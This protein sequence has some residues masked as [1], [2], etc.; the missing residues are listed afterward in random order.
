MNK[1]TL[2]EI[3]E[4]LLDELK[5]EAW[6]CEQMEHTPRRVAEFYAEFL[7]PSDFKF[8]VFKN[9]GNRGMLAEKNIPFYSLCSHHM[10]P[11]YG[12]VDVGYIPDKHYVGISKLARVV[13]HFARDLNMQET[14]TENIANF[15]D[16]K[17]KPLGV[18]VVS[19]A[20]HTCQEM[21]GI[22][23]QSETIYSCI[24]GAFED[25]KARQEFLEL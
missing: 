10:L 9:S 16:E 2:T 6:H 18:M 15:L 1:E 3:T 8:T 25:Y 20:R 24:R 23:K 14:M 12:T 7:Q 17:L 22:K 11:F 21:R 19:R 4:L 13:D 5:G